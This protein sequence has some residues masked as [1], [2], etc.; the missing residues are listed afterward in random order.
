ML[1]VVDEPAE[2]DQVGCGSGRFD[3]LREIVALQVGDHVGERAHVLDEGCQLRAVRQRGLELEP[4]IFGQGV[5]VREDPTRDGTGGWGPRPDRLGVF[6]LTG[7]PKVS[8]IRAQARAASARPTETRVDLSRS[9]RR[10]NRRVRPDT[11]SAKV[12]RGQESCVQTNPRTRNDTTT[13]L[14]TAGRSRGNRR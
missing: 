2:T 3:P 6:R 12:L 5:G 13:N 8:V 11:C 7:A 1:K 14:P 10:P 4:V 9:V